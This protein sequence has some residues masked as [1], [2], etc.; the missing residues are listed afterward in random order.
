MKDAPSFAVLSLHDLPLEDP[1]PLAE[2]HL[3]SLTLE[4]VAVK[5]L[6]FIASLKRLES[7]ELHSMEVSDL[8][9]VRGLEHLTRLWVTDSPRLTSLPPM[10]GLHVQNLDLSRTGVADLAPL[11]SLGELETLKLASTKVKSLAPLA[12]CKKLKELRL[13]GTEVADLAPLAGLKGLKE[14]GVPKGVP[15]ASVEALR[16]ANPTLRVIGP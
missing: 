4:K 5:D 6:G 8:G 16:K 9:F 2:A 14:L 10:S 13:E 11:G 3:Q 12:G 1:A 15:P 7:L